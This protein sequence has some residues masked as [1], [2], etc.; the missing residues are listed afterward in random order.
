[1]KCKIVVFL[2]LTFILSQAFALDWNE[3]SK[4]VGVDRGGF[5]EFGYSVAISGEYAIV[6]VPQ[7]D[8]D[9]EDEN[10]L[11]SAGSA[12]IFHYNSSTSTWEKQQKIVA[13]DR[14]AG[15]QFGTSVAISGDHAIVGAPNKGAN[16]GAAYIFD[17]DGSSWTQEQK[18]VASNSGS[19]DY[20]AYS[21]SISGDYAI[22]GAYGEDKHWTWLGGEAIDAGSA[23]I[24]HYD[25]ST[26][27]EQQ[28]IVA[29][30]REEDAYF[31][32][33]VSISGDHTIV[34]APN[35]DGN[36]G[37]AYIFDYDGSTWTQE[38][39][40]IASDA[41]EDDEFGHSVSISD[42]YAIVGAYGDEVVVNGRT[43]SNA[44]AAYIFH[45]NSSTSTWAEQQQ[46]VASDREEN[47]KFGNSVSIS[48]D[49][50][51]V[52]AYGEDQDAAD[53]NTLS[54]AGSAYLFYY[55]GSDWTQEQKIV[56]LDR[57]L[58]DY[59][60]YSV[61][62]SGNHA[63]VGAPYEE[64]DAGSAYI[65]D[66][67]GSTW[68]QEQKIL[69]FYSDRGENENFGRSISISGDYAIVGVPYKD[70][71]VAGANTLTDAG[72][73][74]IFHYEGSTWIGQQ[75][76]VASDRGLG[77][78][79]GSSV[80]ISGDYAI[81]VARAE[82]ED[83]AGGNTVTDA[84]SAYIFHYDGFTWTEQQ[85]IVASD[86]GSGD[87]FGYSVAIS[88][89][90]AIVGARAEDE[91]AAGG[92]TVTNAGSA[93]I[94]HYDGST[95]TQEQKVVSLD[96]NEW[97]Y[98]GSAVAI[99]G[100]NAI[101]GAE[102][103]D[104]DAA[105]GNTLSDAGA[106]Y[107]FHYNS[108]TS[109]W[110]QQKI[111]ASDRREGD[112]FGYSVSISGDR[113]I[114][115]APQKSSTG[116]AYIFHYDGSTWTQQQRILFDWWTGVGDRFGY[117]VAISG[118]NAIVG[119]DLDDEDAAGGN[120]LSNAGS[121]YIFHYDGSTWIGQQKIVASDRGSGDYFGSS[122]AISGD[123]AIVGARAEDE[124]AA[125]GNTV[126]DAG[127]A[128]IFKGT[129]DTSLPI[130]LASFTAISQNGLVELA[131]ETASEINNVSFVIY[132]N[133]EAIA[134]VSGAGTTS[135]S[136]TYRF[137]DNTVVLGL[138]YTYVLA[139]VD[140]ANNENKYDAKAVTVTVSN[141]LTD[142]DFTIGAAYPNPFNPETTIEYSLPEAGFVELSI[143]D[144]NGR[145]RIELVMDD[146]S[147]GKYTVNWNA[148]DFSSGLYF[149][150]L[151]VDGLVG[152]TRKVVLLK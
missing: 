56:A 62:I 14:I 93:Y 27:A 150:R 82:D 118:N 107:I 38:Q 128:Y 36:T 81:V 77:D 43:K 49:N 25:E 73:A 40:I 144:I 66:Y 123:Y 130:T 13:S 20:F 90:Y 69:L 6:G 7:E 104:E 140:Y 60:G 19:G 39:Q 97:T 12:Y 114:V 134:T 99:S 105:G 4:I 67:D 103:E 85:K 70:E 42:D 9:A 80:A 71:D 110:E 37:A 143:Y 91:D 133:G 151:L 106:A 58:G 126:T 41:E 152:D 10:T 50:A 59:F 96:R 92:N 101:V 137:V 78:Y 35:E 119:A 51:I 30:D 117:S 64:V 23:Y 111:V 22:V 88:G 120:T 44:G 11:T 46:I 32:Y 48:G 24:F 131:W 98:F 95:W 76:I 139:D 100:D 5:D 129:S 15:D 127:S 84:G 52:G 29:S 75:K 147:A 145:K 53:A 45:Y 108:T 18:I 124:D 138:T 28:Q 68:T 33:S 3:V 146:K 113:A 148:D 121:A 86:R 149:C 47:D 83:A 112:H 72:A 135:E 94:F 57:G 55:D 65:F 115:G 31:G 54:N 61:A 21:V 141:D 17:Y 109:T 116:Y 87:Y 74:Y 132:R 2:A 125:G 8:E 142:A 79:F 26:W 63:I 1:M 34:G 89:D 102:W 16:T 122:V 136:H